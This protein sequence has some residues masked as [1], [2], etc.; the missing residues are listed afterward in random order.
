MGNE[1]KEWGFYDLEAFQWS[2]WPIKKI[3]A[4][5]KFRFFGKKKFR[6][7]KKKFSKNRNFFFKKNRKFELGEKSFIGRLDHQK[8]PKSQ[9]SRFL[10]HW[11]WETTKNQEI[12]YLD[13]LEVCQY[14]NWPRKF[15]WTNSNFP[16]FWEKKNFD[17]WI[18]FFQKI[19]KNFSKKKSKIELDHMKKRGEITLV[20]D[21]RKRYLS[22]LNN[23]FSGPRLEI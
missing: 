14:S 17:F 5:S 8:T 1:A 22:T 13:Y 20:V 19:E 15:F 7:L 21:R 2:I 9:F 16:F 10:A 23:E 12:C 18:F 6:F 3:W 4:N 11:A